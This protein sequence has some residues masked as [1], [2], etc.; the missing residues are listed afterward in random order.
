MIWECELLKMGP[1]RATLHVVVAL[2][3]LQL[4]TGHCR[5]QPV[6]S[7][8]ADNNAAVVSG[9]RSNV[10]DIDECR[11]MR[12]RCVGIVDIALEGGN[13]GDEA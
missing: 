3:Q 8:D 9:G 2:C 11:T 1:I 6:S 10:G 5:S 13:G 7:K 12:D 4:L